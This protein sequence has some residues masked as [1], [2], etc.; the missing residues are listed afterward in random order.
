MD[1]CELGFE[2][3]EFE[4]TLSDLPGSTDLHLSDLKPIA[5]ELSD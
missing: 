2:L 3:R 5:L 4:S 1:L